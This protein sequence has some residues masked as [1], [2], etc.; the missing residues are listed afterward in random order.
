MPFVIFRKSDEKIEV[1]LR[2]DKNDGLY[3]NYQLA[4]LIIIYS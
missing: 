3:S 1:L 2:F 4:A